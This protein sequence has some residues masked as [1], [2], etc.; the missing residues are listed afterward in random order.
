[1]TSPIRT[2]AFAVILLG[3]PGLAKAED[4]TLHFLASQ[5]GIW[6]F[7]LADAL[8]YFN[9]TGIKFD[10]LGN[11]NGGPAWLIALAGGRVD[12]GSAATPAVLNA[13]ASG[14]DFVVAYP[15]NGVNEAVH[16]VGLP[17]DAANLVVVRGRNWSKSCAPNWSTSPHSATGRRPL[18]ARP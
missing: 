4:V 15:S 6:A 13:I 17:S 3:L 9:G 8:G 2:A 5:G 1:M 11:V 14:N 12:I 10:N 16:S 7:E 18:T